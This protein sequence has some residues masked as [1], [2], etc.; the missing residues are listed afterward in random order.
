MSYFYRHPWKAGIYVIL[1][2]IVPL[3]PN[4]FQHFC[5]QSKA[6]KCGNPCILWSISEQVPKS[7]QYLNCT[8]S[9]WLCGHSSTAIVGL[10]TTS[11]R[12]TRL[13]IILGLSLIALAFLNVV[14]QQRGLKMWP[15]HAQQP[16]NTLPHLLLVYWKP[17]IPPYPR[18]TVVAPTLTVSALEGFHCTPY[19][20]WRGLL[21]HLSS[22]VPWHSAASVA[23]RSQ[24]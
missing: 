2:Q 7:K 6:M 11:S 12:F 13:D 14:W 4:A 10:C 19:T 8:K 23:T 24:T 22:F 16:K 18:H 9:T 17:Q 5:V 15:L 21:N 20:K 3:V 1:V